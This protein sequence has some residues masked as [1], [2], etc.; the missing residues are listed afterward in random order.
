[1]ADRVCEVCGKPAT[2]LSGSYGD[3]YPE[4]ALCEPHK[5]AWFTFRKVGVIGPTG[6]MRPKMWQAVFNKFL[7]KAMKEAR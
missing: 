7:A 2:W 5:E 1:M 3:R 6:R 4:R